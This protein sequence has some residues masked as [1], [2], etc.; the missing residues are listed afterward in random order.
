MG[1][2]TA[3]TLTCECSSQNWTGSEVEHEGLRG[4]PDAFVC[5]SFCM[6]Q[7]TAIPHFTLMS[8]YKLTT[9]L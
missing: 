1:G 8:R 6:L 5:Y 7:C 2:M 4:R 9:N 3:Y